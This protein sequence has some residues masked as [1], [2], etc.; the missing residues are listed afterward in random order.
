MR[1][2]VVGASLLGF[3]LVIVIAGLVALQAWQS[4]DMITALIIGIVAAIVAG[5]LGLCFFLLLSSPEQ[6]H[7]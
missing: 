3:M 7:S 1:L 6:R 2:P 5:A 4:G